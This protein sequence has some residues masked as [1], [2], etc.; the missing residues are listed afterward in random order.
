MFLIHVHEFVEWCVSKLVFFILVFKYNLIP[1]IRLFSHI[2]HLSLK[3]LT[4]I[5]LNHSR[6][7]SLHFPHG[8]KDFFNAKLVWDFV[9]TFEIDNFLG[10]QYFMR[11]LFGLAAKDLVDVVFYLCEEDVE[12]WK[13]DRFNRWCTLTGYGFVFFEIEVFD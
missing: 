1:I 12:K 9:I 10:R 6:K 7:R 11:I 8:H 13:S 4:S 3:R 5:I 2:D